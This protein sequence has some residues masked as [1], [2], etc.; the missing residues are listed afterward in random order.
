MVRPPISS[1][2]REARI[3]RSFSCCGEWVCRASRISQ[4]FHTRAAF[5]VRERV[6]RAAT[7]RSSRSSALHALRASSSLRQISASRAQSNWNGAFE[8]TPK[9]AASIRRGRLSPSLVANSRASTISAET[10]FEA[11]SIFLP[12]F[13]LSPANRRRSAK[14]SATWSSRLQFCAWLSVK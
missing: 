13:Y 12:L 14:T 4:S 10:M 5:S 2:Q 3:S 1:S 6:N 8:R 11:A 9:A 7:L